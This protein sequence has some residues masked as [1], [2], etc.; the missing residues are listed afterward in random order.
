MKSLKL[1]VKDAQIRNDG[2][3]FHDELSN[4]TEPTHYTPGGVRIAGSNITPPFE[5]CIR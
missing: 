4:Y 3:G 5:F 2:V 1:V